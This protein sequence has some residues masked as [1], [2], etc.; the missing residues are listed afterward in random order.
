MFADYELFSSKGMVLKDSILAMTFA[1]QYFGIKRLNIVSGI[2]RIY[3]LRW[4]PNEK[5]RNKES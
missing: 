2:V 1:L 4:K 3:G 5:N